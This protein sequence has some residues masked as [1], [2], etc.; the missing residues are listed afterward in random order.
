MGTFKQEWIQ[1]REAMLDSD[2]GSFFF[3]CGRCNWPYVVLCYTMKNKI[4]CHLVCYFFWNFLVDN[5][6]IGFDV[7]RSQCWCWY[8]C[9]PD[10]RIFWINC[11]LSLPVSD[12]LLTVVGL[13]ACLIRYIAQKTKRWCLNMC[14]GL[15]K[16][17]YQEHESS[18]ISVIPCSHAHTLLIILRRW[19][20]RTNHSD[21]ADVAHL[22]FNNNNEPYSKIK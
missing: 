22:H 19:R 6:Q 4:H 17:N 10:W 2:S 15:R 11:D 9:F 18:L 13:T 12:T 20:S 7:L 5:D 1:I 3:F 8:W 16:F 14:S 21:K